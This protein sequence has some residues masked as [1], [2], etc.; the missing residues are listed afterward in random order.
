MVRKRFLKFESFLKVSPSLTTGTV[1][2]MR[3]GFM[4]NLPCSSEYR[5]LVIRRRSEQL[6]T[7]WTRRHMS[8]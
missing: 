7:Y 8:T 3:L 6:L 1:E 2:N 4:T 5:S